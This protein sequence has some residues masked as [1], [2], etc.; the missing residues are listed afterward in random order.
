MSDSEL[1][2][3]RLLVIENSRVVLENEN[4]KQINCGLAV[5]MKKLR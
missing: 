4:L 3:A 1:L 2:R 5:K